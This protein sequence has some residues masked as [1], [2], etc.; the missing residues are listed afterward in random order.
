MQRKEEKTVFEN[1]LNSVYPV[2]KM[3]NLRWSGDILRKHRQNSWRVNIFNL[4]FFASTNDI[5]D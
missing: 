1:I 3:G 4:L 5:N 2:H